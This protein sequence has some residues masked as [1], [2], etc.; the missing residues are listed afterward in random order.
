MNRSVLVFVSITAFALLSACGSEPEPDAAADAATA[1]AKPAPT[2]P[3]PAPSED[4]TAKMARAV[5]N[6]KVGAAVDIK[7]EFLAKP[8][9]GT[10]TEV[11]VAFIPNVGVD[12]MDATISGMEG[13]TLAGDLTASFAKVESGKPYTHTVSL[14]PDRMGVFYI[15]V[16]VNT[17]IGGSTL[18]KTFSIPLVVGN[19]PAQKKAAPAKDASGEAIE[20]MKAQESAG[21]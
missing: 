5:G 1:A 8:A 20:P 9:V 2:L 11:E 21:Q 7:Y 14:L 16:A 10:P 3:K 19:P 18:G 12:A 17:Q 13:L 15:T 6:A 4:P